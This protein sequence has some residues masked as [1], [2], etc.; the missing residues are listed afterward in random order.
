MRAG[1]IGVLGASGLVGSALCERLFFEGQYRF[2]PCIHTT[3]NAARVARLGIKPVVVDLMDRKTVQAALA[4]CDVVINCTR[5]DAR[6]M[7]EGLRNIIDTVQSQGVAKFVHLSSLAIFGRD[8]AADSAT[9]E[10]RPQ[11]G[12]NE[13]GIL[14]VKQDALVLAAKRV[15][16]CVLCPGNIVGPFS[17]YSRMLAERLVT[18]P[19]PLVDDGCHPCN[20]VHVDNLVEAVLAVVRST[21]T[22]Q[23]R[24]FVNEVQPVTW[25]RFLDGLASHLGV[26]WTSIPV[27]RADVLERLGAPGPPRGVGA[28]ARALASV[29]FRQGIATL[30]AM[31]RMLEAL[32]AGFSRLPM[33]AQDRIRRRLQWPIRLQKRRPSVDLSDPFVAV[34]VRR[35]FHDPQRLADT[36]GWRPALTFEQGMATTASWLRFFGIGGPQ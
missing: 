19:V 32:S 24:Y 8:P 1:T 33:E 31:G 15:P 22:P 18:G 9:E 29:E 28:H 16:T 21:Q 5:G 35:F 23:G 4:P 26:E 13:Y 34:Q 14:K 36:F 17:G 27:D 25:R 12:N 3:G 20:L 7:I 10:G 2:I 6:T 11:P 30:P